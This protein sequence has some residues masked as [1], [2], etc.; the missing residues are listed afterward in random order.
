MILSDR[1]TCR[2]IN[3]G[4]EIVFGRRQLECWLQVRYQYSLFFVLNVR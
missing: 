4:K 2:M 1:W 3:F